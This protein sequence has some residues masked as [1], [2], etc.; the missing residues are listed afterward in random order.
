MDRENAHKE[1]RRGKPLRGQV[2]GILQNVSEK[3]S[4]ISMTP[5]PQVIATSFGLVV[6]MEIFTWGVD[7]HTGNQA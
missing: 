4:V 7:K 1:K 2:E 3:S 5:Y 6:G